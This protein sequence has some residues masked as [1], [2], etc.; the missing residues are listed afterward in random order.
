MMMVFMKIKII[1]HSVL[2]PPKIIKIKVVTR[3]EGK[4]KLNIKDLK[5]PL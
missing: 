4:V 2:T 1:L 5:A 3:N